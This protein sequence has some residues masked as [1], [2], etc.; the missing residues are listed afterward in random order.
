MAASGLALK[1][2]FRGL[3]Y[4]LSKDRGRH[5][6]GCHIGADGLHSGSVFA[7]GER[8]VVGEK[9]LVPAPFLVFLDRVGRRCPG[10]VGAR[11]V[12]AGLVRISS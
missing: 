11:R 4:F 6:R 9:R 10:W 2:L 1:L 7:V 8:H 5:G 12:R 3:R